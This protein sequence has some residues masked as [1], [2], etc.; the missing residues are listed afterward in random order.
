MVRFLKDGELVSIAPGGVREAL[1]SENYSLVW[2][3]REGFAKA[4]LEAR[5]V[6][7]LLCSIYVLIVGVFTV[8][9]EP[10]SKFVWMTE[11]SLYVQVCTFHD[12]CK[13]G[14]DQQILIDRFHVK[15]RILSPEN[16]KQS[17]QVKS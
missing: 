15:L 3:K 7:E 14:I 11:Q 9:A 16:C 13:Q 12:G 2:R 8:H 5:V 10:S 6:C 17:L 1:F 4:A